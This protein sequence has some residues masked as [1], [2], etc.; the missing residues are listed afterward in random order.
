VFADISHNKR[1][2]LIRQD[3]AL[4]GE[5]TRI[6]ENIHDNVSQGLNAAVLQIRAARKELIESVRL[7]RLHLR[8]A[9]KL[10]LYSLAEARRATS[11]LSDVCVA[12]GDFGSELQ[13]VA[14]HLFS[15]SLVKVEFDLQKPVSF[16]STRFQ[17]ELVRIAK[18]ALTNVTKHANATRVQI[19]L[20]LSESHAELS[21]LDNGRGFVL[22]PFFT[23]KGS[24]GLFNMRLRAERIGG[25]LEIQSRPGS[26]TSVAVRLPLSNCERASG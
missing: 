10:T 19:S 3:Q 11:M 12:S 9:L 4:A 20:R 24:F 15:G 7:T 18:E 26:G 6:A 21:I 1:D 16:L 13:S 25:K 5:R 2:A 14:R 23:Q 17:A 8:K 22:A